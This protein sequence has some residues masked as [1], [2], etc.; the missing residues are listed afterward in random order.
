[1]LTLNQY[2]DGHILTDHFYISILCKK[3]RYIIQNI[4]KNEIK[5]KYKWIIIIFYLVKI[6][7]KVKRSKNGTGK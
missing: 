1:M 4:N 3:N 5:W 2:Y 6:I 7:F